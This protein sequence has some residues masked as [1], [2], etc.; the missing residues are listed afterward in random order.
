MLSLSRF[1]LMSILFVSTPLQ[2]QL[3][4]L[5][6]KPYLTGGG[7]TVAVAAGD[8]NGDGV[9]DL[10]AANGVISILLGNGGGTFKKPHIYAA[11]STPNSVTLA[12]F[13]GDGALDIAASNLIDSSVS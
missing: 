7:G 11:G 8:L 12:D 2:V 13:N 10:V 9:P 5:T 3:Q 1:V 4:F 6:A